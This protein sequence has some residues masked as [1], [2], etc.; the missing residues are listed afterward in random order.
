MDECESL[1]ARGALRIVKTRCCRVNFD[2]DADVTMSNASADIDAD[3]SR[4]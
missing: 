3:D 4:E 1:C 2:E